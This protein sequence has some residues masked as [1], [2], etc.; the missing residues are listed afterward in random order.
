MQPIWAGEFAVQLRILIY[1]A[2]AMVLGAII[3]LERE[4]LGKPAGLRTHMLVAGA[5]AFFTAMSNVMVGESGRQLGFSLVQSDPIR[6]IQAVITGAAFLGAGT[7]IRSSSEDSV[8][9][10]TTAASIFF[11]SAIGVCVA[12]SMILLAVGATLLGLVILRLVGFGENWL[13]KH[14][15]SGLWV[16]PDSTKRSTGE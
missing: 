15:S 7:I 13:T 11:T 12:L 14:V 5:T 2:L 8:E 9:G 4:L 1:I 10:L 3:G 6:I 16:R